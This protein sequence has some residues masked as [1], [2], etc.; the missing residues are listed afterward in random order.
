MV[1]TV[2]GYLCGSVP[3]ALLIGWA[4]GVDIRRVG[5]GNV[6]A[7]NTGR[8]LGTK[9]GG[10]CLVLDVL[11]GITPVAF[12]GWMMG[13]VHGSLMPHQAWRWLAVAAAAMLGHVYP[14]WLRFRGGKGVATGL[15]VLLGFGPLLTVPVSFSVVIWLLVLA[16]SRYVSLASI[17]AAMAVPLLLCG[18]AAARQQL[19]QIT[20]FLVSTMMLASLVIVRHH[21]NIWRLWT[22]T[23]PKLGQHD[24][25]SVTQK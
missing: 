17:V 18:Q 23:E 24:N 10:L 6:G 2:V 4:R 11:K 25:R 9:W 16:V 22:G 5:S 12:A 13:Y 8:A 7:T 20:P 3:F 1:W 15:G 19:G 14:I 21:T